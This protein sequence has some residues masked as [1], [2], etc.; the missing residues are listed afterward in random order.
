MISVPFSR[1]VSVWLVNVRQD[2]AKAADG[3]WGVPVG[4]RYEEPC[5]G[6]VAANRREQAQGAE[7]AKRVAVGR[8][9]KEPFKAALG[10]TGWRSLRKPQSR[11]GEL[12]TSGVQKYIKWRYGS[13]SVVDRRAPTVP[14]DLTP[15]GC[16]RSWGIGVVGVSESS[17]ELIDRA[18]DR[19]HGWSRRLKYDR[20]IQ[21]L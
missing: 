21:I 8:V 1:T 11:R 20:R 10:T 3:R 18:L 7:G 17:T 2:G 14:V 9:V 13:C 5:L 4:S 16:E 15:T 19:L 12:T 6:D